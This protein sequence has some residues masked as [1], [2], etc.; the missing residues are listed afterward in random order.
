MCIRDRFVA[1]VELPCR[2]PHGDAVIRQRRLLA[3][4]LAVGDRAPQPLDLDRACARHRRERVHDRLLCVQPPQPDAAV[5]LAWRNHDVA[6]AAQPP[7][8]RRRHEVEALAEG[9]QVPVVAQAE[10]REGARRRERRERRRDGGR[11]LGVRGGHRA[12]GWRLGVGGCVG[13]RLQ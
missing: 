10:R 5:R 7:P 2:R 9:L 6:A 8:E 11:A 12:V 13:S 1:R 3:H 4:R